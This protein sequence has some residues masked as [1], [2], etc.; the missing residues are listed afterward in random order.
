MKNYIDTLSPDSSRYRVPAIFGERVTLE[1]TENETDGIEK[2][3]HDLKTG[4]AV[5]GLTLI[6]SFAEKTKGVV[7]YPITHS[8]IAEILSKLRWKE[9]DNTYI[10]VIRI[11]WKYLWGI[12]RFLSKIGNR[13][14]FFYRNLFEST[15]VAIVREVEAIE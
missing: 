6:L 10:Q 7:I 1:N 11:V 12:R 4:D 13:E 9:G 15:M 3:W 14:I 8:K 2:R 5:H